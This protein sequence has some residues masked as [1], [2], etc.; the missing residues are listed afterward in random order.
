MNR[1]GRGRIAL[2]LHEPVALSVSSG[3]PD[4]A[5]ASPS[6]P[7]AHLRGEAS[8]GLPTFRQRVRPSALL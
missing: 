4:F 2:D 6:R 7:G 5:L 3:R 1:A 8:K